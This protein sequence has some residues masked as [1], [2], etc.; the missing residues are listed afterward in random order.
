MSQAAPADPQ[1]VVSEVAAE[2]GTL[3]RQRRW[4]AS[5]KDAIHLHTTALSPPRGVL[6]LRAS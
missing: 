3:P 4:R 6:S 2:P 5:G 1:L